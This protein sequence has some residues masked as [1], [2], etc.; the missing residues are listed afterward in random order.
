MK[1]SVKLTPKGERWRR[2][3]HPWIYR[4]DVES[5]DSQCAGAIVRVLAPAGQPVGQAFCNPHSKIVLRWLTEDPERPVDRAFWEERLTAALNLRQRVVR[6]S[7]ACRLIYSEADRFPGLIVD[8][9]GAVLVV[10]SLSLGIDPLLPLLLELLIERVRPE[11][12]VARNDASVRRLEGLPLEK[13][14]IYG[15]L[16]GRLEIQEGNRRF[17]VDVLEG[18]KTGAYLDQRENRLWARNYARGRVLDAFAYQGGFALQVANCA[19]EVLAVEDSPLAVGWIRENAALNGLKNVRAERANAFEYLRA[20]EQEEQR[21]DLVILDPPAFAKNRGEVAD[22][23]RGYRE[24]NL[25]ALKLLSPGGVLITCSCSFL[26]DEATFLEIL[27]EAVA[28]A[29]RTVRFLESRTQGRDHP[30][31]MTHPESRYLKCVALEAV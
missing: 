19:E 26:V 2:T 27:R 30:I 4:D 5:V 7:D 13:G 6:D 15:N 10:Q 25:R 16:P 31:L 20:L 28:H 11:A 9:Y 1:Q 3:G 29:H 12:V 21:F 24:I 22:A 23:R 18:Q 17:L 8:R 14:V